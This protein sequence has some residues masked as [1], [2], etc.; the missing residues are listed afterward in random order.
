MNDVNDEHKVVGFSYPLLFVDSDDKV[1][2]EITMTVKSKISIS[3][4]ETL[5]AMFKN[6]LDKYKPKGESHGDNCKVK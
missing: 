3:R 1:I 6:L 5:I 2:K 4:A